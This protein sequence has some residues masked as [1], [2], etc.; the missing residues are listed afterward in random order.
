MLPSRPLGVAAVVL[1]LTLAG[2]MGCGP[3]AKNSLTP[4][5]CT[6]DPCATMVCP[7]GMRCSVSSSCAPACEPLT[8]KSF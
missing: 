3:F 6:G 7:D 1:A 4:R 8:Y 5:K 2:A